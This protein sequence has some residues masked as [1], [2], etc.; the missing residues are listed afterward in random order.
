MRDCS[1]GEHPISRRSR[2]L[3]RPA[4]DASVGNPVSCSCRNPPR[5][6]CARRCRLLRPGPTPVGVWPRVQAVTSL[7]RERRHWSPDRG[8][9]PDRHGPV[10]RRELCARSGRRRR[11]DRRRRVPWTP[12]GSGA[13]RGGAARAGRTTRRAH[14]CC[15]A[16][17]APAGH[18]RVQSPCRG[19]HSLRRR[20]SL[21]GSELRPVPCL[22][23]LSHLRGYRPA[24]HRERAPSARFRVS[25]GAHQG[26]SDLMSAP[27]ASPRLLCLAQRLPIGRDPGQEASWFLGA[28]SARGRAFLSTRP[29]M[30]ACVLAVPVSAVRGGG[31]CRRPACLWGRCRAGLPCR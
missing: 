31:R 25:V 17:S 28:P 9:I 13:A 30:R 15:R 24:H 14:F 22:P 29:R 1:P 6:R 20:N 23:P 8:P 4:E 11:P 27:C 10:R 18:R 21:V 7:A 2:W 12:H 3:R 16:R 26:P 5:S 19:P